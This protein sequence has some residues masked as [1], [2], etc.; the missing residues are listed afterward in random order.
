MSQKVQ[1]KDTFYRE[2]LLKNR[3]TSRSR[4]RQKILNKDDL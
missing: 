4:K 3:E 1:N 2:G